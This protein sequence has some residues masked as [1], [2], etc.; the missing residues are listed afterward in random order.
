MSGHRDGVLSSIQQLFHQGPVA[1]LDERQLLERF[2]TKHDEAAFAALVSLHGPLVWGVCRRI[3]RDP[4]DMEDAF[5]ATFLVLVRRAGTVRDAGPART[6]ASWGC[7]ARR[8]PGPSRR[9]S[10]RDD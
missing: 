2:V 1:G 3:L 6:L 9:G 5:Q 7:P 10:P 4:P 8:A